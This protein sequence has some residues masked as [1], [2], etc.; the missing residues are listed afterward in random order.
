MGGGG[1]GGVARARACVCMCVRVMGVT[2]VWPCTL[3]HSC[4]HAHSCGST[5][6]PCAAMIRASCV[7]SHCC[8]SQHAS[9]CHP[10]P[11]LGACHLALCASMSPYAT[12]SCSVPH[13]LTKH[14][15]APAAHNTDQGG[16][17]SVNDVTMNKVFENE[18]DAA[19]G[20]WSV[21]I[22]PSQS[23]GQ[24]KPTRNQ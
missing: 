6:R 19:S 21:G 2:G 23:G 20:N 7:S 16:N 14:T 13:W 15:H 18:E 1:G 4:T 11:H 22:K 3:V 8:H 12:C 9:A 24:D 10:A 17:N 5:I